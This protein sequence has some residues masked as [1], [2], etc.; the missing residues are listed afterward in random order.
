MLDY[1]RQLSAVFTIALL[2]HLTFSQTPGDVRLVGGAWPGEGRLEVFRGRWGGVCDDGFSTSAA[3]VVCRQLGF[4]PLRPTFATVTGPNAQFLLDDLT[5]TGQEAA[6]PDCGHSSWGTHNCGTTEHVHVGCFSACSVH[7]C[8]NGG[9]CIDIPHSTTVNCSCPSGFTGL[10]CE[11]A[12]GVNITCSSHNMFVEFTKKEFPGLHADSLT[13]RDL[14]CTATDTP[15]TITLTAPLGGCGTQMEAVGEDFVY[16]NVVSAQDVTVSGHISYVRDINVTVR[17][18]YNRNVVARNYYLVD[19]GDL[20]VLS[21]SQG[22][23]EISMDLIHKGV[24]Y[25]PSSALPLSVKPGESLS[26]KLSLQSNDSNLQVFAR[27]CK[28]TPTPSPDSSVQYLILENG[29]AHDSTLTFKDVSHMTEETLTLET[30]KFVNSSSM[31]Y[32]H[33]EVLVCNASDSES[34]CHH[35]CLAPGRGRRDAGGRR[36]SDL[37]K[38]VHLTSQHLSAGPIRV[39]NRRTK[40]STKF[41]DGKNGNTY[42]MEEPA[43]IVGVALMCASLVMVMATLYL[44]FRGEAGHE[45]DDQTE[46][47]Y[48]KH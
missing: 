37:E 21:S 36:E 7:S 20:H 13:L 40:R 31:V 38:E 19:T 27:N 8:R 17:C 43:M 42:Y 44:L 29:C 33:C 39:I 18:F 22:K 45:S 4:S 35:G 48:D 34:R 24:V 1:L 15:T 14:T 11:Q 23:Y 5:C 2:F 3:V 12:Q 32:F 10:H 46:T 47:R 26:I 6:L 25:Q 9:T 16:V 28:A 30:F 41:A